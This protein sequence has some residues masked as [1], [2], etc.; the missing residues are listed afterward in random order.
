MDAPEIEVTGRDTG[1]ITSAP[2]Y[3]SFGEPVRRSRSKAGKVADIWLAGPTSRRKERCRERSSADMPWA[4][5]AASTYF[6]NA[7]ASRRNAWR[8]VSR[9]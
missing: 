3:A 9:E 1:R 7:S 6:I 5:A 8:E 2:G 4:S